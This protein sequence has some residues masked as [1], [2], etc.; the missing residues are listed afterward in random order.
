MKVLDVV[1]RIETEAK[2]RAK[3]DAVKFGSMAIHDYH[4]QGDVR[5]MRIAPPAK[6]DIRQIAKRSQI[7]PGTT[8]G[9]RHC[10]SSESL[11]GVTMHELVNAT[12]LDGPVLECSDRV[13]ITHP[14]HGHVSVPAG[15]YQIGY[16][17][18]HADEL[19]RVAD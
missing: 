3:P 4:W 15:W 19:R 1:K 11:G 17:R 10:I 12:A 8:Q 16:Q 5:I 2:K 7:A 9:S 6:K 14:E 18:Q 13:E